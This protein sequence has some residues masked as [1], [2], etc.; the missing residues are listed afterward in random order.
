MRVSG[1][2]ATDDAV[3]WIGVQSPTLP[4]RMESVPAGVFQIGRGST[5]HLRLGD[6]SIPEVLALII[7]DRRQARISCQAESPQILLNGETIQDSPLSD[8]DILETGP[9]TLIFRRL[10]TAV[11]AVKPDDEVY[12][13][14]S[15]LSTEQ[16]VDQLD[17]EFATI[18]ALERTRVT[19]LR[20]MMSRISEVPTDTDEV[21]DV[22][23]IDDVRALFR[24]LEQGQHRLRLQQEEILQQLYRLTRQGEQIAAS[25]RLEP[26]GVVPMHPPVRRASA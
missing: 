17:D 12:S 24:V 2:L 5:C 7:A 4:H 23:P 15:T 6:E 3:A 8:G 26:D 19:G 18:E 20:E 14:P 21:P 16:L 1:Q 9:Y 22:I 10:Q 25:L 13:Q 11:V